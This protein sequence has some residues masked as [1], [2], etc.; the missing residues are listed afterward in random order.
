MKDI[1]SHPIYTF[2]HRAADENHFSSL[3]ISLFSAISIFSDPAFPYLP[4]HASRRKLMHFSRIKSITTYHKCMKQL[5]AARYVSYESS[6]HPQ[7][8]ST[9]A[10]VISSNPDGT[11]NAT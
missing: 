5:I 7:N 3:N 6:Y 9:I 4:F 8:A 10:L 11:L 2:I 1:A